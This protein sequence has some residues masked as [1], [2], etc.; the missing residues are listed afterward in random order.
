MSSSIQI[1]GRNISQ[2]RIL[3]PT[4]SY[5]LWSAP[6]F[7][8]SRSCL[9][10]PILLG[11]EWPY[12]YVYITC[13]PMLM[14]RPPW[15]ELTPRAAKEK[16]SDLFSGEILDRQRTMYGWGTPDPGLEEYNRFSFLPEESGHLLATSQ[17]SS[18]PRI[19][20]HFFACIAT[21]WRKWLVPFFWSSNGPV[22]PIPTDNQQVRNA[23]FFFQFPSWLGRAGDVGG[24]G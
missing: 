6:A 7:S 21:L 17:F 19:W 23:Y 9:F 13:S 14:G 5:R 16:P 20:S 15:H 22:E 8:G 18:I 10:R 1:F 2:W 4:L 12:G 24:T 3:L 11:P